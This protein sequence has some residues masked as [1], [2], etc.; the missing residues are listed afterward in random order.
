SPATP[1]PQPAGPIAA[2]PSPWPGPSSWT[3]PQPRPACWPPSGRPRPRRPAA[4]P[5]SPPVR[6]ARH[7][8]HTRPLER[9]RTTPHDLP[10]ATR[11]DYPAESAVRVLAH[12]GDLECVEVTSMTGPDEDWTLQLD[13]EQAQALADS[14]RY[15][16]ARIDRGRT[17][18]EAEQ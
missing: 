4:P 11:P 13:R 6:P 8:A 9:R 15:A 12:W 14:L 18:A 1:A 3:S 7:H 16:L 2:C 5:D 17:E 10:D